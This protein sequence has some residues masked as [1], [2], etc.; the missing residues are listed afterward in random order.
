MGAADSPWPI[1]AA[2]HVGLRSRALLV[3]WFG[4]PRTVPLFADGIKAASY[5]DGYDI[6]GLG[7][8]AAA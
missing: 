3:R 5:P 7:P 8:S 2:L 1:R 4:R 6:A